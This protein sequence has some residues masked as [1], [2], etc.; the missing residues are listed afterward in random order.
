MSKFSYQAFN[1]S[2]KIVSG[3]IDA[4]SE[5]MANNLILARG[6]IPSKVKKEKA[7]AIKSKELS[8]TELLTP[9]KTR[10]M[11]LLTKQIRTMLKVGVPMIKMLQILEDQTEH[12]R[13]RT[14]INAIAKHITEGSKIHEAFAKHP[15]VFP[16]LY[17]AALQAG[18]SSGALPEVLERLI[19][20]MEHEHKVRSD[21]RA[22]LQY[23]IFVLTFLII[24]F[25]FLLIFVVPKFVQVFKSAKITLP[26][27]T[28]ICLL[29][30]EFWQHYW[31]LIIGSVVWFGIII[32]LYLKTEQGKYIRDMLLLK[33][34]IVGDLLIKSAMSRFAS[35][36]SI[37]Q[38]SGVQILESLKIISNAIGNKA[39]S[40]E[41]DRIRDQIE[42][43]S[44]I[45]APLKA[46][47][48]F[49]PM[50]VN[51]VA[52]GEKTEKLDE[53]LSDVAQHY[54]AEVE[55]AMK[56]MSEYMGPMLTICMAGMVG[57]FALAIL[58]PM[59]DITKI[60]R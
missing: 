15:S 22:A 48:Y 7:A 33:L 43:G 44:S 46:A 21:I 54:D 5:N 45:S 51:M 57:F 2:G 12:P 20:I 32:G 25:F 34:P 3:T 19:Y 58:M 6:L 14:V 59:W 38:Y 1:D 41:F 30:Y 56:T 52:I 9:I 4:D 50:V 26:M 31:Y 35:I 42:K 11:I 10:D 55:Y 23:P 39:V 29:M 8:F 17:C 13:L 49:T 27:P 60:A 24:A 28:Q 37:L 16:P 47:K 40:L 36:F 18:E 53:M